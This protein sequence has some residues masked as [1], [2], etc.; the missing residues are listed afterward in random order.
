MSRRMEGSR[1]K[2]RNSPKDS[3]SW[4]RLRNWISGTSICKARRQ[5]VVRRTLPPNVLSEKRRDR[6]QMSERRRAHARGLMGKRTA[7]HGRDH[8]IPHWCVTC[9]RRATR[10]LGELPIQCYKFPNAHRYF[11]SLHFRTPLMPFKRTFTF[12]Q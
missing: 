6:Q 11:H 1:M 7:K 10:G 3:G 4:A 8:R 2:L 9:R 5:R 12:C